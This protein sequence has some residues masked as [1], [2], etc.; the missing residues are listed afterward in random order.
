MLFSDE[1]LSFWGGIDPATG[2]I[3]D[4]HHSLCGQCL[5]GKVLVLPSGRGSCT[6]SAVMLQLLSSGTGPTAVIICEKEEI[7]T[8]GVVIAAK[9]F[10]KSI[11]IV[12]LAP[13][14]FQALRNWESAQVE[15]GWVARG[16]AVL[17][18]EAMVPVD[19][20]LALSDNDK[21]MLGGAGSAA[22]KLAM[23]VIVTMSE[24]YGAEKLIDIEQV[25][26]DGCIYTG[27]AGLAFAEHLVKLGAKVSVPTTLN[28]ISVDRQMWRAL[29][30]PHDF[31]AAS[32][33]LADAYIA[34][35]ARPT[36]TCAPYLLDSKPG[37]GAQVAWGESNA[38]IYANS[39]LGARTLKYPDYLDICIAITGRAPLAGTHLEE[40]RLP[41]LEIAVEAVSH[42]DDSFFPLLGYH[43]GKMC[44]PQIPLVTGLEHV[45]ISADDLKAFSAAFGTTSA[46]PMFHV[47]GHTPVLGSTEASMALPRH[48]V[49]KAQLRASWQELNATDGSHIDLIALGNPHFSV[50]EFES[51]SALCAGKRKHH[52]VKM[53]V[54]CG[55]DVH[56]KISPTGVLAQLEAFGVTILNDIC[57]CMIEKPIIPEECRAIGTN[58]GKYIHY[59]PGLSGVGVR[60][61]S[62]GDCV[63]AAETGK[64][65][66][67]IPDWL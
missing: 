43:I 36:Y 49:S 61:G 34:M 10:G 54:T 45:A 32:E 58:S 35:G 67:R 56:Q 44:G 27:D 25:H 50:T 5:S 16:T 38:V 7:I 24:V 39:V 20:P 60:L 6:G 46:A 51:L 23:E 19:M 30:V 42:I 2:V 21:H 63:D 29:G 4:R 18:Q 17:A 48:T 22:G 14:D 11:P 12:R 13:D 28:A 59:G 47:A 41:Q 40:G 9:F 8:L 64:W 65:P 31:G 37:L 55:R 15:N 62:L 57:W 3:I 33:R 66:E 52:R 26:I 53:I 1:P